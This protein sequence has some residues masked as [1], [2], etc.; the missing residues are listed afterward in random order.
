MIVSF[1]LS[2]LETFY[3]RNR[4]LTCKDMFR[5]GVVLD[6]NRDSG[7]YEHQEIGA[8]CFLRNL[9]ILQLLYG[10]THGRL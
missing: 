1:A 6:V 8:L 2:T 5:V 10:G 7:T 9:L 3:L 4:P